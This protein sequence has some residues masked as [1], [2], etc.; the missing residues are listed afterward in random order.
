MFKGQE[1]RCKRRVP[2]FLKDR[3]SGSLLQTITNLSVFEKGQDRVTV[4]RVYDIA[5]LISPWDN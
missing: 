1:W 2:F 5:F 4:L 3:D